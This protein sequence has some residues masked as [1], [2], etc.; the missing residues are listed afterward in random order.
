MG[1]RKI[2]LA[3][4]AE[5]LR[6]G[7]YSGKDRSVLLLLKQVG[8]KSCDTCRCE[9]GRGVLASHHIKRQ[10]LDCDTCSQRKH[11]PGTLLRRLRLHPPLRH[12]FKFIASEG[13]LFRSYDR[14]NDKPLSYLQ[15]KK[16]I[17]VLEEKGQVDVENVRPKKTKIIKH[18]QSTKEPNPN[19][20]TGNEDFGQGMN[21]MSKNHGVCRGDHCCLVIETTPTKPNKV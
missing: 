1:T 6:T 2:A 16:T 17:M 11:R 12:P 9:H 19:I 20:P 18:I 14:H 7:V 21:R 10:S 8:Y 13:G 5:Y 4:A 15:L 3:R